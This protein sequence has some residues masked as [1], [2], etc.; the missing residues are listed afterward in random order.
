M[1]FFV[2]RNERTKSWYIYDTKSQRP[3]EEPTRIMII[4]DSM[5]DRLIAGYLIAQGAIE[6]ELE[7]K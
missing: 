4:A 3:A 7:P 5:M 1:R 2:E 6:L